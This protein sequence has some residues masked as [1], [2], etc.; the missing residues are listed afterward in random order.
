MVT[1][2]ERG[3]KQW[4]FDEMHQSSQLHPEWGILVPPRSFAR[5]VRIL[6]I[7]TAIGITA[8]AGV[9]SS[10]AERSSEQ[11]AIVAQTLVQ[12]VEQ[13]A[14][15]PLNVQA[16]ATRTAEIKATAV[17]ATRSQPVAA[18]AATQNQK[19]ASKKHPG[20]RYAVRGREFTS[21]MDDWYHAVGL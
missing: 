13:P 7:A 10:L 5:T 21:L 9:M 6:M 12:P 17:P 15:K 16:K 14:A 3:R 11:P 8:G 20:P 4:G 1:P 18:A 2:P 19:K